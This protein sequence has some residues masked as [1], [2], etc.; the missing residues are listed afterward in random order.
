VIDDGS[1]IDYLSK[2]INLKDE[3]R[4]TS[5]TLT[6]QEAKQAVVEKVLE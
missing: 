3:Q 4:E 6:A 5:I 1:V 2:P